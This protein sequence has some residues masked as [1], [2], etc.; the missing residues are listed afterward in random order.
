MHKKLF[1]TNNAIK[2]KDVHENTTFLTHK[3]KFFDLA[4][5]IMHQK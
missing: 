4:V 5:K 3:Q 2:D 1:L